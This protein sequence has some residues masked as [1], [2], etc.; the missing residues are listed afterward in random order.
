MI[1]SFTDDAPTGGAPSKKGGRALPATVAALPSAVGHP[2]LEQQADGTDSPRVETVT[3]GPTTYGPAG[4]GQQAWPSKV[5]HY[6][7]DKV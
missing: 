4:K 5:N 3:K 7:E 6:T 1:Q 2:R